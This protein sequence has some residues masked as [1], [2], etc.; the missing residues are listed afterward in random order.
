MYFYRR[1]QGTSEL[2]EGKSYSRER[3]AAFLRRWA[4]PSARSAVAW[5]LPRAAL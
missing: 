3:F 5:W 1:S 4:R 2:E